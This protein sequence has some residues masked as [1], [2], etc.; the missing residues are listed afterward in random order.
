[1]KAISHIKEDDLIS[2][3]TDDLTYPK[4]VIV[5]VGDDCAVIEKS[6]TH[7]TLLKTDTVVEGVHFKPNEVAERVGW[8]AVARVVSDFASMGGQP[9]AL[10]ITLILPPETSQEWVQKLYMGMKACARRFSFSIVGGETSSA[11]TGSPIVVSISGT[12]IVEAH[13]LTLRNGASAG[14]LIYVTGL[15][16][17]SIQGK[18][19]DFTPRV[20]EGIW[21]AKHLKPTAMMDLSDGIA[22]DLP[23]LTKASKCGFEIFR[24]KLPLSYNTSIDQALK[25]GEDYEL[26]FTIPADSQTDLETMWEQQFPDLELTNIGQITEKKS[27]TLEGGW[28]HFQQDQ[29][30]ES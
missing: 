22:K 10:L 13:N 30:A 8:K 17:N 15:L 5:G 21:L 3:L 1:M 9:E 14:D 11:P 27:D 23:R 7:H 25:D 16:G 2:S 12:G 6:D 18:H 28:D 19:L 20:K 4:E 24:S 26:L 29:S